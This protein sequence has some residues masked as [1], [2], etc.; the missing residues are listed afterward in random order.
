MV[1]FKPHRFFTFNEFSNLDF[2]LTVRVT[3]TIL[4]LKLKFR[5]CPQITFF[6]K[7]MYI[8]VIQTKI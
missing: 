5:V 3:P 2:D 8:Y 4:R 7:I 1:K 6:T